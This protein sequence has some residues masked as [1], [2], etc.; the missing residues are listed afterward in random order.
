MEKPAI[1]IVDATPEIV[2]Q[3]KHDLEQKYSDLFRIIAAQS[4]QQA[5]DILK[6]M[7]VFN[8]PVALL[9][10]DEQM[11][12][13]SGSD[14]LRVSREQFPQAKR[15]L[16]ISYMDTH[17]AVHEI[18]EGRID[19]Y[20]VKPWD[21]PEQC[22]YPAVDD[23]LTGWL[24]TYDPSLTPLRVIDHRWSPK[25]YEIGRFLA[26]NQVPYQW[27]DIENRPDAL[28]LLEH[29][30]LNRRKLPVVIFPD[31]SYLVNPELLQIADKLKLKTHAEKPFYD[32]IIIGSGPAGLAAAVYGASEGLSAL[33]VEREAPGGQA[34]LSSRIE[35][36]LGFP[37]GLSGGELARRAVVQAERFG[38]EIV[39]PQK[40]CRIKV[41]GQY[42]SVVMQDKSEVYC[43][44]L[45]L[46]CGVSYC[47][48]E[49]PGI[50]SLVG[51]G[52]YYGASVSEAILCKNEDVYIVG[53]ANSAGQAAIYFSKY[54]R[55]VTMLVRA[56]SLAKDMSWYL[57]N[58]INHTSNI[59]VKT[60]TRVV[61]VHG[62]HHLES[63]TIVNDQSQEEQTLPAASL[64]IFIGT[65]PHTGWLKRTVKCDERGFIL[66]GPD[67]MNAEHHKP[68]HWQLERDPFYLETNVP[69]IF[70]AGDV[71]HGSIKRVASSVG[72]GSMAVLLIHRYLG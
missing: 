30:N 24:I 41:N 1:V 12:E 3:L 40:A 34:G 26:R 56:D 18:N 36:Y 29:L 37:T 57:I 63:I 70:A 48:L 4:S 14:L 52:V 13:V 45:L 38:A 10:A 17:A 62:K 9:I 44:T 66:T 72:E 16:L 65:E 32:L 49:V 25:L 46:A 6:K 21:P 7:S 61:A 60:N 8:E 33:L 55:S 58:Q 68:E 51:A 19:Y 15:I 67:L 64:F 11:P 27:L 20:I 71:R 31:G 39:T 5:L 47:Q 28:R 59:T 35:N 42:R 23:I 43:H 50:S 2:Q 22:L 54:A 69:G 53:G